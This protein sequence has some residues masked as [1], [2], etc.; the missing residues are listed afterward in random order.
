MMS[1]NLK[2]KIAKALVNSSFGLSTKE[3]ADDLGMRYKAV[4]DVLIELEKESMIENSCTQKNIQFWKVTKNG[5]DELKK[6][7]PFSEGVLSE[8]ATELKKEMD[9]L[10]TTSKLDIEN[11]EIFQIMDEAREKLI[12]YIKSRPIKMP[13]DNVET[14][15]KT[16]EGL[17]DITSPQIAKVLN[18]VICDLRA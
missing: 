7:Y 12:K 14:K 2:T 3:I 1:D 17:A 18:S 4:Y 11:F 15:I 9:N 6:Q 5:F 10:M 8:S 16:L 13:I